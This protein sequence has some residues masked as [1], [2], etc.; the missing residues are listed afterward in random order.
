MHWPE[1]ELHQQA[2][3]LC[4]PL[5]LNSDAA[6]CLQVSVPDFLRGLIVYRD[7]TAERSELMQQTMVLFTM[8]MST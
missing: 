4:V 8:Q 3:L 1:E 5:T 6:W 7:T 2:L